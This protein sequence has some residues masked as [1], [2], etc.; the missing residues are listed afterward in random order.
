MQP[1][2]VGLVV[3][4]VAGGALPGAAQAGAPGWSTPHTA[5]AVPVGV[6]A[7][8]PNGQGVQLFGA[9]GA[10]QTRVAQ[11][12]AIKSDATQGSAVTVDA[13]GQPGIGLTAVDV[14][15]SGHLVTAWS[16]D[17]QQQGP[18]G[19]AAALGA[20]TALPR[21]AAVLPST[22]G[23][24]ALA[25]A[26]APD[27]TG[28]VAWAEFSP[29]VVKVATLRNG[30]APQVVTFAA[31]TPDATL[32]GVQVGIDASA[33]PVVTWTATPTVLGSPSGTTKLNVTRGGAGD[34]TFPA[35]TAVPLTN[36]NVARADAV[37]QAGG[38]L[39]VVW[40]EGVLP[41]ALTV[42]TADLAVGGTALSPPRLLTTLPSGIAP[43]VAGSLNGRLAVFFLQGT[44]GKAGGTPGLILRSSAGTWGRQRDMGPASRRAARGLNAGV[45]ASGRVVILWDDGTAGGSPTRILA[46]RSSSS[47]DPPGSYH[48]LPQRSGDRSCSAPVLTLS[49]SGDGLGSWQCRTA[50][51]SNQPRLARLTA[52]S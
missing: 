5:T 33:R 50:T 3:L 4:L 9:A 37:V 16:L 34:G 13:A 24:T 20:R 11:M 43:S 1:L 42:R 46:A 23:V 44:G 6:Y 28:T 35:P 18:I 39:T 48:Q 40:S 45:D 49:T 27:G 52:A 19:L 17:A 2:R 15:P 31:A 41:G 10:T 38:G 26:I 51:A 25:D 32:A 14:N 8:G 30:T 12:R 29:A 22:G 47:S 36:A 21:T 7:A